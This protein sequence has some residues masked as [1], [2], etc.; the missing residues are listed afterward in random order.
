MQDTRQPVKCGTF[1]AITRRRMVLDSSG[2]GF[3]SGR[4]RFCLRRG[5]KI[6]TN[7]ADAAQIHICSLLPSSNRR[8]ESAPGQPPVPFEADENPKEIGR[9]CVF[10]AACYGKRGRKEEHVFLNTQQ[11]VL[12]TLTGG[13]DRASANVSEL[14]ISR[15]VLFPSAASCN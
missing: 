12:S 1:H 15:N 8:N 3:V 14:L 13:L 9:N 4:Q 6:S 7:P 2:L 10:A 11:A 5:V